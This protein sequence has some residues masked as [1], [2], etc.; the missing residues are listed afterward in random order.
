MSIFTLLERVRNESVSYRRRV[1]IATA[2]SITGLICIG[3]LMSV[4]AGS[5]S[6]YDQQT[7]ATATTSPLAALGAAFSEGKNL[8]GKLFSTLSQ[9]RQI[10]SALS[11]S[12]IATTTRTGFV[13]S[14]TTPKK[15][16]TT[17]PTQ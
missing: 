14:T 10:F 9:S 16:S 12:T 8:F 1:A 2:F 15:V 4:T 7:A 3:W 11:S 6:R 13:T 5:S 17:T